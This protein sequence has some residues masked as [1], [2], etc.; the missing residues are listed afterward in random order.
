MRNRDRERYDVRTSLIQDSYIGVCAA[1]RHGV[2]KTF[3]NRLGAQP[4]FPKPVRRV[5]QITLN[6][7]AN[8]TG[9]KDWY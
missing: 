8:I 3:R 7:Q 2:E 5:G 9:D 6:N 4:I 1:D